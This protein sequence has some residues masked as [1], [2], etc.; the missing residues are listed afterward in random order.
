MLQT[1]DSMRG[2]ELKSNAVFVF[3]VVSH[4]VVKH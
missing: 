1:K 2:A 4:A 3:N